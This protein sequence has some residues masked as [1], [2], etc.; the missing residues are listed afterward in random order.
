M[1]KDYNTSTKWRVSASWVVMT[2]PKIQCIDAQFSVQNYYTETEYLNGKDQVID[3]SYS[4]PV[5]FII[6]QIVCRKIPDSDHFWLAICN[7]F[8]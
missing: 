2:L 4:N 8:V 1:D 5:E 7:K 6:V 3:S